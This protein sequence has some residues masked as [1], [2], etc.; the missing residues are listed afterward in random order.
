ME[1]DELPW[2]PDP[3]LIIPR[4]KRGWF[5]LIAYFDWLQRSA[6]RAWLTYT[7]WPVPHR[8]GIVPGW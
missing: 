3:E 8:P 5:E 4:P 2:A 1:D 6:G 7:D